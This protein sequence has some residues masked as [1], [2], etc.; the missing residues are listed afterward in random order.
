LPAR[1]DTKT[2]IPEPGAPAR[3]SLVAR[4]WSLDQPPARVRVRVRV[5][6]RLKVLDR[7]VQHRRHAPSPQ[8][9]RR[10]SPAGTFRG[11]GVT[12]RPFLRR[13]SASERHARHARTRR[14]HQPASRPELVT[15]DTVP[16]GRCDTQ[17]ISLRPSTRPRER[18]VAAAMGIAG[19]ALS[20]SARQHILERVIPGCCPVMN[21]RKLSAGPKRGWLA[22]GHSLVR[23]C[24]DGRRPSASPG[25]AG[26]GQALKPSPA[27]MPLSPLNG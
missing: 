15:P 2:L 12:H 5:R 8:H 25:A 27:L 26:T 13:R 11:L 10:G 19:P 7:Q 1:P 21:N 6:V 18:S 4:D 14:C 3:P 23:S 20:T 16:R 22:C 9:A 24:R 17:S